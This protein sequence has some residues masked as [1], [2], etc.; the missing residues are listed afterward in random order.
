MPRTSNRKYALR[1]L[2]RTTVVRRNMAGLRFL[3]GDSDSLEDDINGQFELQLQEIAS[4]RYA[5]RSR[6]YRKRKDKW[7]KYLVEDGELNEEEFLAYFRV[8][9]R[10]FSA[11]LDLICDDVVFK[12]SGRRHFRGGPGLHLLILLKF[13]GSSGNDNTSPELAQFFGICKRSVKNYIQRACHAMLRL[14]DCTIT[15]PDSEDRGE[16]SRQIKDKFVGLVDGAFQPLELKPRKNGEDYFTR[17]GRYASNALIVSD[18]VFRV[19]KA[20][21]GWPGSVHDNRV[22]PTSLMCRESDKFFDSYLLRDSAFQP[23]SVMI[24]A[25]KKPLKV[26]LDILKKYFNTQLV[27]IRIK[28]ENCNGHFKTRFPFLRGL[29]IKV[30]G[31]KYGTIAPANYLCLRNTQPIDLRVNPRQVERRC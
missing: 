8:S 10:A 5:F 1:H 9:C 31:K 3:L 19:R 21:V 15:W 16:I 26:D 29:R 6:K 2:R 13:L 14:Q 7:K 4:S 17:K 27:K 30:T 28:T 12:H 23:S 25:F 24:H 20:V 22:W 18:D 11:L